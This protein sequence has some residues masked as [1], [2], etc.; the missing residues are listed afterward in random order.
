M[1]TIDL[2]TLPSREDHAEYA[3]Y[4]V[5]PEPQERTLVDIAMHAIRQFPE[6]TALESDAESLTYAELE[7]RLREQ[8]ERLHELGIGRGDRI[9]IRVP[10]GTTDLYVAIL[11]TIFAGAAYVPVD[12]DD[13]DSRANTVWEEA[14]VAAV[15]GANLSIEIKKDLNQ[16]VVDKAAPT[17]DDDAWI[18]FTSGS[19]GK[20]KGV[21]ITHRSAAALVDAE[22]LMYLVNEPLGPHD[23]V[24]A[25]LSVAFDASCEEMWLAWRTGATLVCAHRDVVRSGDVLNDWLKKNRITAISTV[26]TLASF[27]SKEALENIRLLIFGG[28]AL[29]LDLVERLEDP[30]REIWNSYG[31]TEATVIA[32]GHLMTS[33]PPVRIG[34]PVP[35]WQLVVVDEDEQPVKWGE[36]G[37]LI[38]GGVGLGRYLDPQKDAEVYASLPSMGWERAYRTGDLVKAEQEGLI[39][40]G[41]A[42]D[43]IKFAGRRLELG[44]IDDKLTALTHVN[45]GASRLNKTETGSDVLVGYLVAEEGETI[46]LHE[47]R[48]ELAKT[49][50]GGI[51]PVLYVMDEMPMKTSGKVDRKA[52]PWPLPID[53]NAEDDDL[54][55]H[56]VPLAEAWKHQLGPIPLTEDSDFFELG[57]SSVA[58]AKLTVELRK[59]YPTT[60]IA[61]L[62]NNPTLTEMSEYLRTL[63]GEAEER[64][65]PAP[66]PAGGKVFQGLWILFMV[67]F[68]GLRYGVSALIVVWAFSVFGDAAWVPRPPII[69]LLLAWIIFYSPFGK[70]LVT[71]SVTK[72]LIGKLK[73]GVYLR[74]GKEHIRVWA[75]ERFFNY[76]SH[77][78][79]DGTPF[80]PVF[81]RMLGNKIGKNTKLNSGLSLTGL[82]Y[83][84]DNATIEEEVDLSG[85]W[86]D[87]DKFYVGSIVIGENARIGA[88]SFV[89]PGASVGEGAEILPGSHVKGTVQPDEMWEG[90]PMR[91][92]G[93]A[94]Q[95]WPEEEPLEQEDL[96]VVSRFG[97]WLLY[98]LGMLL[99]TVMPI[100]AAIPGAVFIVTQTGLLYTRSYHAVFLTV[101]IW[102]IPF[103]VVSITIWLS[104]VA[105]TVRALSGLI[106]PGFWPDQ[107]TTGWALWLTR[108]LMAATLESA[109]FVY[110]SWITPIWLRI[111]GAQVG[112][113]VEISTVVVIPHLTVIKDGSFLADDVMACAPRYGNGWVHIGTTVIGEK[114]FVGNSAIV[115][116]DRDMPEESLL[117]VLSTAPFRPEVGS[118]WMGRTASAIPRQK[119]NSNSENTYKP[120]FSRKIGR[121]AVEALR[122]LPIIVTFVIDTG[123]VYFMSMVYVEAG[124]SMFSLFLTLLAA[125]PIVFCGYLL[126]TLLPVA[127]KWIL[128]GEFKAEKQE[129]HS[130]FV[131][132]NELADNFNEL[133]AVPTLVFMSLGS[134]YFNMWA[135]LMGSKIGKDVWCE[136]WWL[137]EFDLII[138]DDNATV[139][140]G[141]V[142]QTHL[143]HD[144][145]MSLEPVHL[146]A[147]STLG[148]SSFMLPGSA[149]GERSTIGPASLILRHDRIPGD[150]VWEGNPVHPVKGSGSTIDFKALEAEVNSTSFKTKAPSTSTTSR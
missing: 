76:Q 128:V 95:N 103:V 104:M 43:Q 143:F 73:P 16:A 116:G 130:S 105:V 137:P 125:G 144:R 55:T 81:Y 60:D 24:M 107:S 83:V 100:M 147:G 2:S 113:D 38:I 30:H 85:H 119:E 148:P 114:S 138:I 65:M 79:M 131:W 78:T 112:K 139:N 58:I 140:R 66:L 53:P 124:T 132:R 59:T 75:A 12:W 35:G 52:L 70:M 54:P 51:V 36:T 33:E 77:E 13:P 123:V 93:P 26:P 98:T 146:E 122:L 64:D 74:G 135:R 99:I 118:S 39:F 150:S 56:L 37:Q 29:P 106:K 94:N 57:G 133:L 92:L 145:V 14:D 20:P 63:G 34:R 90:A 46:D 28:E 61:E 91:F 111:C 71:V 6:V 23:R 44:E 27:W 31:P 82:T 127:L 72:L 67:A 48:G 96:G 149:I 22:Q 134:P 141:T 49:M 120:P 9:G 7:Q 4:G 3:I 18:I 97:N 1:A 86:I 69:P 115:G 45:V 117:A 8:V 89:S 88:R 108:A 42:D 41:R 32:S 68:T 87:G 62:Y 19:T 126:S 47:A 110:A 21:A 15:Y 25:G 50:P 17:L 10:S 80:A 109:Y 121:A 40:A 101:L 11:A 129:L 5:E 102:A 84:G 136:T 142:L